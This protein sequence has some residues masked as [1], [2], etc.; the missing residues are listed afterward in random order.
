MIR[1]YK[2][3]Y[4]SE[5][6]YVS[7][8][9]LIVVFI[10]GH[11]LPVFFA[12]GQVLLLSLIA[13]LFIDIL[14]IF[15]AS[16][17]IYA[18]RHTPERL[19]NGDENIIQIA[20]K[21]QYKFEISVKIID[22]IPH[23]FQI[24]NMEI[25]DKLGSGS[26]KTY[27]YSLHPVVRGEY[28]FGALNVFASSILGLVSRRMLFDNHKLVPV[29]PSF[30][31][32][33]KYELLAISNRLTE[34]GVKKIRRIS[35]NNEFEQIR[36][37][38]QG[39][40]YRTL[41]WKATARKSKYMVNQYQDEKSQ[42]VFSVIDMGRAMKMPFEEMTLLDYAINASL[43]ISKIA[44]Y[45]QDRAG[46]ITFSNSIHS[47]LPADRKNSQIF[48]ILETL[49]RQETNFEESNIEF[50]YSAIKNK[51]KQ[52]SLILL[53]TNFESMYS[54]NRQLKYLK[55]IGKNHLLVVVFFENTEI[56]TLVKNVPNDVEEIYVKTIA[57][58]F[59]F[60]KKLIIKEL[61]KHGIH[62]ILTEPKKLTV[63]TINKYLEIKARGLI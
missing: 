8:L 53:Y 27:Q 45:K 24:R 43:V 34:A 41:N 40:D 55:Q 49:Y 28:N 13:L 31:Q 9:T 12:I 42:Q 57:E 22:E 10:T 47:L 37:Y 54:L 35:N 2:S 14:L 58:K 30:M 20:I 51:I 56:K 17:P 50:V 26:E 15:N 23:Q 36:E 48:T 63:N 3:I 11:F 59:I 38:V 39:D 1:F 33:R 61:N 32:M 4:L 62:A 5:R 52:R 46:L 18:S 6:I 21:N 60:E 19:S 44:M 7:I 29:Y 16:K 25:L